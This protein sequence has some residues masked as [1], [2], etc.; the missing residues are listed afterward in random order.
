MKLCKTCKHGVVQE[1][2]ETESG[3][4]NK[5]IVTSIKRTYRFW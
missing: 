4:K 5:T 2:K 3:D 1:G